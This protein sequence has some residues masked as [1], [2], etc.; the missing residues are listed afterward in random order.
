[1]PWDGIRDEACVR[2]YSTSHA[3][4][5]RC[6]GLALVFDG[7]TPR[8]SGVQRLVMCQKTS[9]GQVCKSK[10]R[11]A[12]SVRP[13]CSSTTQSDPCRPASPVLPSKPLVASP[14]L[15]RSTVPGLSLLSVSTSYLANG[16]PRTSCHGSPA[17][18]DTASAAPARVPAASQ[19]RYRACMPSAPPVLT[20]NE[21][22]RADLG[23]RAAEHA[24]LSGHI[25]T[26]T[27]VCT[28]ERIQ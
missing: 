24:K 6:V 28:A 25:Y 9:Q 20:L 16:Q 5:T 19:A 22:G 21:G 14:F 3:R 12:P 2:P 18:A 10:Q 1:M 13:A 27:A 8:T 7:G 26:H 17:T 4:P 23:W 15:H 11:K